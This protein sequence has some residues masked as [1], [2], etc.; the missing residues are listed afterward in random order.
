VGQ[1]FVK[2]IV[3]NQPIN[4]LKNFLTKEQQKEN[5]KSYE[6]LRF[7]GYVMEIGFEKATVITCDSFKIAVGG[8]PRNSFLIM[9][10]T[11]WEKFPLHFVLLRVLGETDTPTSKEIREIYFELHKKSMP[12]LD[13]FTESELQWSGLDTYIIGT[14]YSNPDDPNKIEF[15]GDLVN[16]VSAHKYKVYAPDEELLDLIVNSS[17]SS[18]NQFQMGNLRLTECRLSL[19]SK[20]LPEVKVMISTD[21]FFGTRTVLFGKTRQ[22][23]SNVMKLIAQSVIEATGKDRNIGQLIFDI[24]GEYANDNPQDDSKSLKSAYPDRCIVFAISVKENTESRS[25]KIDFYEEPAVSIKILGELLKKQGSVSTYVNNFINISLFSIEEIEEI[26]EFN[27]K[28]RAIRKIQMY[29]A[30]LKKSG[31]K[32]NEGKLKN[33]LPRAGNTK[34][35]NPGFKKDLREKAYGNEVPEP[36]KSLNDLIKELET[37]DNYRKKN[38]DDSCFFTSSGKDLFDIDDIALLEFLNPRG[39]RSGTSHIQ[40]YKN[41]HDSEAIK[42]VE[43]I[44]EFLDKGQTV[45]L[46]LGNADPIIMKYY[47]DLLSRAVFN[48]QVNKFANDKLGNHY[49]QIYFEEAHNLFPKNADPKSIYSRFAKEGAKFHIGMVYSTQSPSTIYA[50][51]LAQTENFFIFHISS[52][53]EVN[54]LAKLNYA[55]EGIKDDILR[56]KTKGFARILTRSHRFVIPVQMK[57]FNPKN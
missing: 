25:L 54:T 53:N 10:P 24:A 40:P 50:D 52:Q 27:E 19:Y 21:D 56:T 4:K 26:K 37:I 6:K 45:I 48:H 3:K 43:E 49:I 15:S 47:S 33:I 17:V 32:V 57:K 14:F 16:F 44:I 7:V 5:E 38:K 55:F 13:I 51:L 22:G 11:N 2:E 28:R 41:F 23:K 42:T 46:D 29:W 8:I 12:E 18:K 36:P 39:G 30:I 34:D 9:V 1:A 35:F 20:K 31:Y